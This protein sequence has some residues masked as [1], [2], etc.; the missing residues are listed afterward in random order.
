MQ[1]R[2]WIG[3]ASFTEE[4]RRYFHGREEEV[5][6]LARRVQRKLLTRAVW[7]V[8]PRQ[9]LHP[10]RRTGAT[11]ARP[12]LLPRLR[13]RG[14]FRRCTRSLPSRSSGPSPRPPA[15]RARGRVRA[16]A[17]AGETL[18][19]FLH[20]RDDVLKDEQGQTLIPLLIFDQFEEVFTLAQSDEAGRARAARFIAELADLVENR[21]PTSFEAK[22]E[23]DE[24]LAE[25]FDFARSD[26]RVLIALR[27]DYLAQLESLKAAM[28]SV[29]Q[30]RQRLAPMNGRQALQAV[31]LPGGEP[32]EPGSGRG[33]RALRRRRCGDRQRRG[34]ALAAEPD[35][36]RTQRH[37]TGARRTRHFT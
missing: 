31:L 16:V 21:P 28:P 9:D 5:A 12:G 13:A 18:W 35:L 20:H 24:N 7:P 37:A 11:T 27:E 6:E 15:A 4:S 22:L 26:Y 14:L 10:A 3:L 8:W 30:N 34:G 23:A 29:T 25:R 2:P 33:H 17:T 19:E 1:Q 32:G 36:P